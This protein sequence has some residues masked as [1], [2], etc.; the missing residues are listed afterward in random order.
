MILEEPSWDSLPS[1][2]DLVSSDDTP[3]NDELQNLVPSLLN[4]VLA[5]VWANR[6][7]WCFGISMGIFYN[8]NEPPAVPNA[9]LSLGTQRVIDD[10]EYEDL[11]LCY[12]SWIEKVA[13]IMVLEIVPY[14]TCGEEY[15]GK[16]KLYEKLGILYYV[17]YNPRRRR[18]T[19]FEVFR[20]IDGT[21]ILQPGSPVWLEEV[22]LGIGCERG[23]YLGITRDWLYWYDRQGIRYPTPEERVAAAEQRAQRLAEELRRLGVDPDNLE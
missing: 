2:M 11:R 9:F 8:P 6:T 7:D 20:L 16:R 12:V 17:I 22:G 4:S 18:K 14:N 21:Y 10:D 19:T 5:G 1:P 3:V 23:T 15:I 13:P